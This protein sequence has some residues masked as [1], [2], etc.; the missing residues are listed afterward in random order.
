MILV[1]AATGEV[2]RATIQALIRQGTAPSQIVAAARS[3]NKAH[4]LFAPGVEIR[5]A[6]YNDRAS[7]ESSFRGIETVVLIPTKTMPAP[8]CVEHANALEAARAAGV[9]RIIFLSLQASTPQSQF[10]V[11]PFILFAECATRLSG[12]QWVFVRMSLFT[13]PIAEW[14]PE[15]V[16]M[17]RLPYPVE[18]ARIAYV[19]RGDIANSLA[20][21]ARNRNMHGEI[22]ELTGPAA[23]S[24]PELAQT[25][26]E[27]THATVPF[28]S[29]PEDEYR[30][31]CR[32][33]H[34][35][36]EIIEILVTMYRAAEAQEFSNVTSDVESLTGTRPESVSEAISRAWQ[37]R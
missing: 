10:I 6:D 31:L 29:I 24:M 19:T 27:I 28:V 14:V 36:E 3:P 1:M 8:R 35:P 25:I 9:K 32:K 5:Q 23:L 11:A 16:R 12:M 26:S 37:G 7:M 33:D 22:M 2:G 30:D 34:L 13:D 15:L 17:G 21:I 20:A 18:Q 4:G